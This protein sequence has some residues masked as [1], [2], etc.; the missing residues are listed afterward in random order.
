MGH[1][2]DSPMTDLRA[3]AAIWSFVV[4]LGLLGLSTY[5]S[6]K[7]AEPNTALASAVFGTS[8]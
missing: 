7:D 2:P 4:L 6:L 8:N 5:I 3:K 1:A